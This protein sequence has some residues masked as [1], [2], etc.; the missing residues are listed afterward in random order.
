MDKTIEMDDEL[1]RQVQEATGEQ[2]ER[3]A[4]EHV[5][6]DHMEARRKHADLLGSDR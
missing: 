6:K 4:V 5:L 3:E 2:T 1:V